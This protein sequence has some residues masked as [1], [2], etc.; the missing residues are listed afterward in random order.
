MWFNSAAFANPGAGQYGNAARTIS[1]ARWQF[2]KT[3][4]MVVAKN[5]RMSGARAAEIR[6]EILNV[7]NT[8]KFAAGGREHG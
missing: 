4:D 8:A 5:V 7:T 1:D 2:R 3:L 6:F